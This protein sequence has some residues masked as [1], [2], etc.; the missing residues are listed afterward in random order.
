MKLKSSKYD[1]FHPTYYNPYFLNKNKRPYVITVYDMIHEKFS[2][3]YSKTDLTKEFKRKTILDATKIIAISNQTKKDIIELYG[4]NEEKIS[5]VY[6]GH[7]IN[8]ELVEKVNNLPENYILYIGS[9]VSYK[10]FN[11][12]IQAFAILAKKY[13]GLHLVC[14]GN[15]FNNEEQET[16][17]RLGLADKVHRIFAT[18]AQ[19]N[20]LYQNAMCFVYPS[21][22]EGF[23]IPILEAFAS[24][25]PLALSNTSC[26]PEIAQ[27]G[28]CYFDPYSIDSMVDTISKL[29]DN[30]EYREKQIQDG[31][32]VLK[33]YS[34]KKMALETAQIYKSI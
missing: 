22:Y 9:R 8:K 31:L 23:G 3:L 11:R 5:V 30:T 33:Q 26:F 20:Y 17:N 12:F 14:T 16:F 2:D 21:L 10:N 25:C 4:V 15:N 6:L 32:N 13:A 29:I 18:D 19:L 34:W 28:G 24:S 27:E 7:S 1:I